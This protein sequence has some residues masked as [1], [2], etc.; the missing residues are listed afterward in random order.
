MPDNFSDISRKQQILARAAKLFRERGYSATSM[1]DIARSMG[2]EAASLYNHIDSKQA[3]LSE[4]LLNIAKEF[5]EGMSGI[6]SLD[7][8]S[9]KKL[10]ALVSLHVRLTIQYNDSISL[11]PNEWVHLEGKSIR[12]FTRLRDNYELA[13]K[14]IMND[15][16]AEGSLRKHNIE[17]S[18]FS[19]LS[20]LR[21]LYSWYSKNKNVDVKALESEMIQ[22]LIYGL[23][24]D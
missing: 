3:I 18:S 21:W 11:I 22:S 13:F 12:Q 20:T 9:I 17:I 24:S 6:Q 2:M 8:T 23:K 14:K 5:T 4:L 16:I 1:R 19:I 7:I 10:E 15:C